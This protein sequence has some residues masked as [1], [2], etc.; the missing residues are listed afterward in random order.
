[1]LRESEA[2]GTPIFPVDEEGWHKRDEAEA[3]TEMDKEE[4]IEII[5]SY[6]LASYQPT[7]SSA[8]SLSYTVATTVILVRHQIRI[9]HVLPGEYFS[10]TIVSCSHMSNLHKPNNCLNLLQLSLG[11][12]IGLDRKL[13]T[14]FKPV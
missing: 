1:M 14:K 11:M 7:Y 9:S 3:A 6:L 10:P 2:E 5:F 8:E 13:I 4:A 12:W